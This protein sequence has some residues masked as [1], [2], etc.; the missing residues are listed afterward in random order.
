MKRLLSVALA[1]AF[2]C[3]VPAAVRA[4]DAPKAESKGK[5]GKDKKDKG[6]KGGDEGGEKKGGGGW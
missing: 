4:E 6:K 1:L 3:T 5:K 2:L